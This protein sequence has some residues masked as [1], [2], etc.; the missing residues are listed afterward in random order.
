MPGGTPHSHRLLLEG[1]WTRPYTKE[2]AFFPLRNRREDK[3]WPLVG[4]VDNIYG[5][6]HLVRSCP[7]IEACGEAAE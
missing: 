2:Q 3:Y 1:D 4:R 5:D 6:R 7:P